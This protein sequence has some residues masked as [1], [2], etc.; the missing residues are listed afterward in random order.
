MLSL[1][2]HGGQAI[3]PLE[4]SG[5]FKVSYN[6]KYGDGGRRCDNVPLPKETKVAAL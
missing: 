5:E 2:W 1:R 3:Y 4:G 6:Y